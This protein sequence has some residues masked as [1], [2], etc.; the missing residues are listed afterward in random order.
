MINLPEKIYERLADDESKA[1][2]NARWDYYANRD[3]HNLEERLREISSPNDSFMFKEYEKLNINIKNGDK[4]VIVGAG[5]NGGHIYSFLTIACKCEIVCFADNNPAKVGNTYYNKPVVSVDS[6]NQGYDDCIAIVSVGDP[7]SREELY[8]QL[9]SIGV[10]S[11]NICMSF[12][13]SKPFRGWDIFLKN[14]RIQYFDVPYIT[15]LGKE[16]V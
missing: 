7:V 11:E 3:L 2:F 9:V 15:P 1:L 14:R 6:L 4:A 8:R 5:A 12:F 13:N 10:K 16:E